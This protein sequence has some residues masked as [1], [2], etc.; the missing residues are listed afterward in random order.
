[1]SQQTTTAGPLLGLLGLLALLSSAAHAA[2]RVASTWH[3]HED[4]SLVGPE[5]PLTN[6]GGMHPNPLAWA[7]TLSAPGDTIVV[8]GDLYQDG[9]GPCKNL[10][11]G[12]KPNQMGDFA[13]R[14]DGALE[15][16]V[17]VGA[18]G[19]GAAGATRIGPVDIYQ[20]VGRVRNLTFR[21]LTIVGTWNWCVIGAM[22]YEHDGF[23]F[24]RC[25]F[26][27]LGHTKW[28]I[29][30]HGPSTGLRVI[31]CFFADFWEHGGYC[32]N[33]SDQLVWG[34]TFLG[35]RRTAWQNVNRI[36]SGRSSF[37]TLLFGQLFIRGTGVDGAGALTVTGHLGEVEIL[38]IDAES[39][40]DT[41]GLVC[42]YEGPNPKKNKSGS[43]RD[44]DGYA[45]CSVTVYPGSRFV[46]PQTDK[47]SGR[48]AVAVSATAE[49]RLGEGIYDAGPERVAIKLDMPDFGGGPVGSWS[50]FESDR[51]PTSWDWG[52]SRSLLTEGAKALDGPTLDKRARAQAASSPTGPR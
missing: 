36:D 45:L 16:V 20:K 18:G 33:A 8:H 14:P 46:T 4:G 23:C 27:S 26:E 48:S 21:D 28:G 39:E 40:Y 3:A 7:L 5:G 44:A 6:S 11:L 42:S 51:A 43:Y 17:I 47:V 19:P 34:C 32:D 30:M 9:K 12:D 25:V 24:E 22:G 2:P 29:R 1:M 38:G 15:D 41:Y 52:S 31:D 49:L 35:N 50:F 37:G 10:K 13:S